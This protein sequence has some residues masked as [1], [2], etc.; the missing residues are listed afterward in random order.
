MFELMLL[1]V[2]V[3]AVGGLVIAYDGSR[4]VFHPMIF[5]GPMLLFLYAW[6]P[7][8]LL[9]NNALGR[10][11]DG[12]QLMFVQTL[13]ILGVLGFVVGCLAVGARLPGVG[14]QAEVNAAPQ[15][16]QRTARR[17]L[18]GSAVLGS[19]GVVCW[20][21]SILNVGGFTAAFSTSYS[22]GQ[23]DSGYVRDGAMLLL[24]G[25]LLAV[26]SLSAGGPRLKGI[27]LAVAFGLPWS[28]SA[29]LMGRRGP[30]FNLVVVLLMGWYVNRR[31]RPPLLLVV[32]GGC[33][34]GWFVLFLV[35]NR[36]QIYLGSDFAL[37]TD[38]SNEVQKP[39]TGNE[40]I[41]GSGT[42]LSAERRDHYFWMKRYLAQVLVRPI[43]SSLW[44]TK[45][46]DFGVPELLYN[47]GTGEGFGDT[48]GWVGATGSAP[49]IIADFWLEVWWFAPLLMVLVGLG[50]GFVWRRAVT[51]GGPWSSQYVVLA[52]LSIYLVMQTGEAVIFRTLELS[53]PTWLAWTWALR[54]PVRLSRRRL[55]PARHTALR[56]PVFAPSLSQRLTEQD[57]YASLKGAS[58]AQR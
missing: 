13:N 26:T 14:R 8:Q 35:T 18:V 56:A 40:Y 53:I 24:V 16:S 30:T 45:Y 6:M 20:S 7:W 12:E 54:K 41:Y 23:D 5:I 10:F 43:P 27:V 47:A 52:A 3:I 9:R 34:L 49:G 29:L 2:A 22:G 38:V 19:I 48:L 21:I 1:L 31:K 4:D 36:Q 28:A 42:V 25:L 33:L 11:F 39:D 17:L 32:A 57:A 58:D 37:Q 50:Y 55:F 46:E 44:T 51:R 15:I